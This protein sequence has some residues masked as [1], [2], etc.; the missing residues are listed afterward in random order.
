MAEKKEEKGKS[1]PKP[2]AKSKGQKD[3]SG[4]TIAKKDVKAKT[5]AR[6]KEDHPNLKGKALKKRVKQQTT[7]GVKRR[8]QRGAKITGKAKKNQTASK[9]PEKKKK[10]HP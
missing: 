6:I 8:E 9:T 5:K 2:P 1:K 7:G 10:E 3:Q 4:R